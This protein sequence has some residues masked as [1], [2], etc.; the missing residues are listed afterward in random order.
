MTRT[1]LR[2]SLLFAFLV[3]IGACNTQ[4]PPPKTYPVNGKIVFI[5][6]GSP[7]EGQVEFRSIKDGV[8]FTAVGQVQASGTF[9]LSTFAGNT[10]V[11]GA[12][13]GEHTVTY[14]S[15][16]G[17]EQGQSSLTP[18]QAK[19]KYTVKAGDNDITVKLAKP[20]Q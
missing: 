10:K 18:S 19:E 6:G 16:V 7:S 2:V 9:T 1:D 3:C 5:E 14:L 8:T 4:P 11:D 15:G 13:E 20:K 17:K 12:V